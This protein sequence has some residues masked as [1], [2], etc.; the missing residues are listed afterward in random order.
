MQTKFP[1]VVNGEL[2]CSRR[3]TASQR[4]SAVVRDRTT[5]TLILTPDD[6]PDL[7]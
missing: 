6:Q 2:Y 1:P 7:A 5:V 3:A 4:R